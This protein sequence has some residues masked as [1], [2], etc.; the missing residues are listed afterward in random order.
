MKVNYEG[1]RPSGTVQVFYFVAALPGYKWSHDTKQDI[2]WQTRYFKPMLKIVIWGI[3]CCCHTLMQSLAV[4]L[5]LC[6]IITERV[7]FLPSALVSF[8]P[9]VVPVHR[10]SLGNTGLPG[11]CDVWKVLFCSSTFSWNFV[12]HGMTP[13]FKIVHLYCLFYELHC[14]CCV[15]VA[16]LWPFG[17]VFFYTYIYIQIIMYVCIRYVF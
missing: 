6:S 7:S 16:F 10:N 17:L 5:T 4:V 8:S 9:F 14:V 3:R 15:W 11:W 13:I 1:Y 2:N 12:H